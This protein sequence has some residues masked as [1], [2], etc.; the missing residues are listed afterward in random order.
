[1][2]KYFPLEVGLAIGATASDLHSFRWAPDQ[3]I[4]ATFYGTESEHLLKITFASPCIVRLVDE[5][6]LSTEHEEDRDEGLVSEHFAY[7]VEGST[8][9]KSQ[10]ETWKLVVGAHFRPVR[11]YRFI[12]GNTCMD[13]VTPSE[14]VFQVIAAEAEG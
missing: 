11:H 8:F 3:S 1:M 13:V 7:L 12:T 14:P 6:P 4:E 10:S 5:F 9:E 2:T